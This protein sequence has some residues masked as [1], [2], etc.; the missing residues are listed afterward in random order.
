[1]TTSAYP[2]RVQASMEAP[3]SRWLW[4]VKWLLVIP[5]YLVLVFLWI[6]FVLLSAVAWVS[7]VLTGHYPRSIFAFNVGVLRWTWRVQYYAYGALGTDR[8]PPFTLEDVPDYPAR[9]E[10]PYPEHLSRGLALVKWWLLAIPHY[11]IAGVFAGGGLWTLLQVDGTDDGLLGTGLIGIM[12]LI[13]GI[14][15]MVTGRYPGGVFDFVLGMNRWV[16]RVAA[17]AGLMTDR[18]PPFRLDTGGTDP[19]GALT[20]TS[21]TDGRATY[22][23]P[24]APTPMTGGRIATLVVAVLLTLTGLGLVPTGI[25]L[26]WADQH[27]DAA[28]FVTTGAQSFTTDTAALTSDDMVIE[29]HG[30]TWLADRLG[31]VRVQASPRGERPLFV[32]VAPAADVERW[33]EGVRHDAVRDVTVLPS[34]V[35]YDR[36]AGDLVAVS[37]PGDQ[38]FWTARSEGAGTQ[39]VSWRIADGTWAIVVANADGSL[40]VDVRA[41]LGAEVPDLGLAAWLVTALGVLLLAGASLLLVLALHGRRAAR[42]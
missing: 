8:Y 16:L 11:V 36:H 33:L 7:I 3:L 31:Q 10:I 18:Y 30:S 6:A 21:S 35:A 25:A 41:E 13:A 2:I 12:V 40:G 34:S 5:H 26:G 27:R 32:G 19:G 20:V 17:Y 1:M 22:A 23:P 39:T 24:P 4:L 28:G 29:L 37:P 14:A 38:P 9:L 15:L 42:P